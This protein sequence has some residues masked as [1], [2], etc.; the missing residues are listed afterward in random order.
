MKFLVYF[1][2]LIHSF[3]GDC[4]QSQ[5]ALHQI[6]DDK[7]LIPLICGH[8]G[9]YYADLPENS[10]SIIDFIY[11]KLNGKPVMFEIDIRADKEGELW[12]MHDEDMSRTTNGRGNI[13][14][15]STKEIRKILLKD[16]NG[17]IT[18]EKIP[19]LKDV[20]KSIQNKN[21]YLMLD[22][23]GNQF[24]NVLEKIKQLEFDDRCIVLTFTHEN[25]NIATQIESKSLVSA[26]IT[27][28]DEYDNFIKL[29][30]SKEKLA[31]YVTDKTPRDI[32]NM[33]KSNGYFTL[34]DPR[35]IWNKNTKPLSI[36]YYNS[37]V[38]DLNLDVLVTD[39]PIEVSERFLY[40][41]YLE[42]QIHQTHLQKFKWFASQQ[43]DS[44]YTLLHDDVHYIHSNGWKESKAEVIA[45]I[46]SGKLTYTDVKVHESQTRIVDN[47]GVVTGKGTFYVSMDGKP[48][49][50][51]LYY[52][53][54]YVMTDE[55]IQLIS[56][57]ACKY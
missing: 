33:L 18:N 55:G 52:T 30:L 35:E 32:L 11:G 26:L 50:F 12:L 34:S 9:G 31:A 36:S 23:K 29:G 45:N 48:Y 47:T 19:T 57:H 2:L 10:V 1:I 17:K 44:L 22:I 14:S 4:Q 6:L 56:R 16:Q 49:A 37:F 39:F 8:R 24:I 40:Q 38:A 43:Y 21:I 41:N 25:T 27:S 5:P 15:K 28:K 53:E 51:D 3:S 13:S 54:V 46:K 42:T 20:I 7:S